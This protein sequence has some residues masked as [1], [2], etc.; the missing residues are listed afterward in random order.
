M[1]AGKFDFVRIFSPESREP[2]TFFQIILFFPAFGM[3]FCSIFYF[4]FD[5]FALERQPQPLAHQTGFVERSS[6]LSGSLLAQT[7]ILGWLV[8]PEVRLN[9]AVQCSALPLSEAGLPHKPS[10]F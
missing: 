10:S 3:R 8:N 9:E 2:T 4:Y 1:V 5:A 6:K 7:V